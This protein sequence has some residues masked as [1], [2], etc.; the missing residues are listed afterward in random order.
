MLKKTFYFLLILLVGVSISAAFID[1]FGAAP[2]GGRLAR[3]STAE[4]Y[5]QGRFVN[6][7]ETSISSSYNFP[8][9]AWAYVFGG[10]ERE[11]EKNIPIVE[12]DP[13]WF[14]ALSGKDLT[15]TWLGHSTLII[16][17]DGHR[18]ITDPMFSDRCSPISFLGPSR[19]FP[20]PI[21]PEQLP[22]MD[23]VIISH[24][25][26]DHLDAD[27]IKLL[28]NTNTKFYVPLGVGAHLEAWGVQSEDIVEMGWWQSHQVS[29]NLTLVNTP[30]RH[31]SG[32]ALL[33]RNKTLWSSWV[34]QGKYHNLYFSGDTGLSPHFQE[35]G[36]RYGPFDIAFLEVGAFNEFWSNVHLGPNNAVK[37]YEMLRARYLYPIHWATFNLALH[38][39]DDP[40][41]QLIELS[42][43]GKVNLLLPTPGQMLTLQDAPLQYP[44]W[45]LKEKYQTG[46]NP[47]NQISLETAADRA[48]LLQKPPPL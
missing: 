30:A 13:S 46:F 40:G 21:D 6:A 42:N 12:T 29:N 45:K 3:I 43:Q 2:S 8:K 18:L 4:N 38:G 34:I 9:L 17:I 33:D 28:A 48:Q 26:Y 11:P 35:I 24:D 32:R 39:W 1:S 37:A 16:E 25:H 31:F 19:F 36:D 23:G 22:V 5:N 27:S 44:W 47:V 15:I 41:N 7:I 14:D 10:E 20:L